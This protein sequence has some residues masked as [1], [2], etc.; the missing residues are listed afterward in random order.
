MVVAPAW[1]V[2]WC[3]CTAFRAMTITVAAVSGVPSAS[4][5]A[6]DDEC[7]WTSVC[8]GMTLV[9]SPCGDG[10]GR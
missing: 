3:C 10:V 4:S 6:F 7:V 2:I 1:T 8:R 5:V 9:E